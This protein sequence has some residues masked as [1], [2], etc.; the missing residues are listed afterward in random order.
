VRGRDEDLAV[1]AEV[2]VLAD[3]KQDPLAIAMYTMRFPSGAIDGSTVT[4]W[5][6]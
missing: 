4:A 1:V 5:V 3:R 2:D 6:S